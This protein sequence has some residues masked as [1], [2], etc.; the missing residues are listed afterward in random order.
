MGADL[1]QF[2]ALKSTEEE[3]NNIYGIKLVT[4]DQCHIGIVDKTQTHGWGACYW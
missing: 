3:I 4:L 1:S 2:N